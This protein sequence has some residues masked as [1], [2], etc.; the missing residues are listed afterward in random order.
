MA[1]DFKPL[2]LDFDPAQGSTQHETGVVLFG[3][4][5]IK[6]RA[7]LNGF[8]I[9]FTNTDRDIHRITVDASTSINGAQ[10]NVDVAL[11]LRDMSGN[12]D[13]LFQGRVDVVVLADVA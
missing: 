9:R 5:V 13:D 7:M 10:V 12:I 11:L 4:P 2:S 8:D 1:L 3:G 6:A